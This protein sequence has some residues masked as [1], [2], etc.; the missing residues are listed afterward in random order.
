LLVSKRTELREEQ[1]KTTKAEVAQRPLP[2]EKEG[3]APEKKKWQPWRK[4]RGSPREKEVAAGGKR[5]DSPGE[6]EAAPR[7]VGQ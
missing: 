7:E 5:R 6:R 4:R 2:G 1:G 3:A